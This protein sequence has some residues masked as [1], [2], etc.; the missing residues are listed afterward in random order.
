MRER[1]SRYEGNA[2]MVVQDGFTGEG[3][4]CAAGAGE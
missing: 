1:A 4:L 2:T 3:P